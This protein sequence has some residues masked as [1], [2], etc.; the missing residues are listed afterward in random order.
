MARE[1]DHSGRQEGTNQISDQLL[2]GLLIQRN[3]TTEE[4][5]QRVG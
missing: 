3:K 1:N 2:T 5:L 4:I